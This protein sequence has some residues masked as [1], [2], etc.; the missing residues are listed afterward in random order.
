M[1]IEVIEN[2]KMV[3][4]LDHGRPN[5]ERVAIYV[6][7]PCDL[8]EYCMFLTMAGAESP[9][10]PVRDHMLW[11]GYGLVNE[12]DWIFVY[13]A[14][15]STTITTNAPSKDGSFPSRIISIHWGKDHTIFQNRAVNPLLVK[16]G[17]LGAIAPPAPAYQGNPNFPRPRLF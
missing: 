14:S 4:V 7:H 17:A 10:A 15:G 8:S 3:E 11:F 6:Q 2:L 13:T 9:V 5:H 16:I 1:S 12:G